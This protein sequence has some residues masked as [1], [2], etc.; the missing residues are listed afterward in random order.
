MASRFPPEGEV[1]QPETLL[2][3]PC[4]FPIKAMGRDIDG[5]Q[6]LVESIV[7]EHADLYP[8]EP[9]TTNS[10]ETGKFVSVT[11]TIEA[12]SKDQLDRIYQALTDCEQVVVAL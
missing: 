9:V 7:F 1:E 12:V 2:E 5:F 8:D 6:A 3:F 4:K 11:V 10:S